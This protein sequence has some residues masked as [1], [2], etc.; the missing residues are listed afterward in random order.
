MGPEA[1]EPPEAMGSFVF[2]CH[3]PDVTLLEEQLVGPCLGSDVGEPPSI[4][5]LGPCLLVLGPWLASLARQE[6]RARCGDVIDQ[7]PKA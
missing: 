1:P 5:S 6:P 4:S 2:L 3:A 7:V